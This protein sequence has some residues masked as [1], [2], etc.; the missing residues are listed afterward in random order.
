MKLIIFFKNN[1]RAIIYSILITVGFGT[2]VYVLDMRLNDLFLLS[3]SILYLI[4]VVEIVWMWYW[5]KKKLIQLNIP[6]VDRYDRI[7]QL[8]LHATLP[9]MLFWSIVGFI[10]NNLNPHEW[11]FILCVSFILFF[12]LFTNIRAYYEDK[13]QLE[14]K[15]HAVY[16]FIKLFIY[17]FSIYNFLTF[18]QSYNLQI[19]YSIIFLGVIGS[20]LLFLNLLQQKSHSIALFVVSIVLSFVISILSVVFFE[21]LNMH[22]F[23]V[24][25]IGFLLFYI[26]VSFMHHTIRRDLTKELIIEYLILAMLPMAMFI[27]Y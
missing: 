4:L 20:V 24:V 1:I 22:I 18:S 17:V 6:I 12:V 13:F 9:T 26:C 5:A 19:L 14:E 27:A 3:S 8:V 11:V 7:T 21:I 25:G 23:K 10:F 15:T 16:D 2:L